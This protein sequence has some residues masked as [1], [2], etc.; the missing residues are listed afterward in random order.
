MLF[1]KKLLSFKLLIS[2]GL[3]VIA[4][5]CFRP[6][7]CGRT[8]AALH[9]RIEQIFPDVYFV[10]GMN[11]ITHEG[12]DLQYS[13]NMIIVRD[14]QALSLINTVRLSD[15]GLKELDALGT[16]K[17]IVRIGAFHGKH[18]AFYLD[19]YEGAKLWALEGMVDQNG[20][21]TDVELHS[22]GSMPFPHC[23]VIRFET[24]KFPEAMLHVDIHD[25]IIITCDSLKNWLGPD[26]Y[27]NEETSKL[28]QEQEFFGAASISSIWLQAC[29]T[30]KNDFDTLRSLKFKH[31]LSAHG[32]PL[33]NNAYDCV[34]T[35]LDKTFDK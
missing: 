20:K 9:S 16:V 6:Y 22:N 1:V 34:M 10:M 2:I 17:N 21:P 27:F 3:I 18:D 12:V 5:I 4:I 13:C 23:S 14:G 31:L 35:T 24:S 33:L 19:R 7:F 26:E 8:S 25:G 11:K 29:E 28:Y 15:K 30:K 32:R